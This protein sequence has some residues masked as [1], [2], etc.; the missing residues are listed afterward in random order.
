MS[1]ELYDIFSLLILVLILV[2]GF[3]YSWEKYELVIF[4]FVISPWL[5]SM[6]FSNIP[7]WINEELPTGPGG[8]LRGA[9]LLFAGGFGLFKY[10][11]RIHFDKGG[12]PIHLL[13]LG[14]FLFFSFISIQYSLDQRYTFIRASLFTALFFFLIGL[15]SWLDNEDNFHKLLNTLYYAILF[16]AVISFIAL[17]IWSSRVWW[18]KTP[19]RFL[20]MWSHPNEL[21]GFSM[22]A[23]PVLLWKV[24]NSK[25]RS[26]Y[27]VYFIMLIVI[28]MH[29]LSGSRTSII[30]S[31]LGV[32]LWFIIEKN[33]LKFIMISMSLLVGGITL[34]Q[35]SP[36]SLQRGEDS[37]LTNLTQR[38]DIWETAFYFAKEQPILG[39]GYGVEGKIF[40]DQLLVDIEGQHFKAN[41]QQP[42]HNGY[43]SI[44]IGVGAIGFL[45]W[46]IIILLPLYNS[47]YSSLSLYKQY[48]I[49]TIV[50]VLIS[51]IVESALT[52]YN[53]VSDI[54]FWLAWVV[55]GKLFL[56]EEKKQNS[57][58][59]A[60][61]ES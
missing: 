61:V 33:W 29:L 53:S 51:N 13:L 34:Y 58:P 25:N 52:G 19:T 42:L 14:I 26:K 8:Y 7:V 40:A 4:F 16:L 21:G 35:V 41:A 3:Y 54:F 55:A 12:I 20:G 43:L 31:F 32:A 5:F 50:M 44:F 56:L 36:S 11:K 59:V 60:L 48:A 23:Y 22:L 24:Y 27:F 1:L 46:L 47:F 17:I 57:Q 6:F 28:L 15:N 39:Y 18:W 30:G 10:I 2:L 45:L 38:E 9:V 49:V 37:N